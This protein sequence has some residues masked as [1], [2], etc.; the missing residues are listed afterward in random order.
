MLSQGTHNSPL[1]LS[2]QAQQRFIL[3]KPIVLAYFSYP[4]SYLQNC[5][6]CCL[7]KKLWASFSWITWLWEMYTFQ[8]TVHWLLLS[9]L[10]YIACIKSPCKSVSPSA[11]SQLLCI[12]FPAAASTVW[13]YSWQ[14]K[15]LSLASCH[16]ILCLPILPCHSSLLP[17]TV[18][19]AIPLGAS[20]YQ[21]PA[22]L[23]EPCKRQSG[24]MWFYNGHLSVMLFSPAC[25]NLCYSVFPNALKKEA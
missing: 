8:M 22:E 16:N 10:R 24:M 3:F 12:A 14:R 2:I 6:F 15:Y 20:L 17:F 25:F 4:P 5:L 9:Q 13:G 7:E 23:W 1:L 18:L 11:M 19:T 21:C